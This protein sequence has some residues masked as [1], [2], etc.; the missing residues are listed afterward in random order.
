MT[1]P[2]DDGRRP[3][4]WLRAAAAVL[5]ASA[6]PSSAS[7]QL[8]T[9]IDLDNDSFNFWQA[10]ARR[11]DREYSQG[12]RVNLL[13]PT[14][15]RIARRLL[16]GPHRCTADAVTRDCRMTSIAAMQRIYTP[17]LVVR[18]RQPSE[19]PF[20]G[21]LGAEVGVQR[22]RTSGLTAWSVT[23]GVTGAPSFGEAAQ[24]GVH[25]LLGFAE[26]DGWDAQL[27]T[28]VAF[29][30]RF[31]GARQLLRVEQPSTGL[32][33]IVAPTW[34]ARVGT[35]ATDATAGISLTTGL[36]PPVPWVTGARSSGDRWGIFVRAGATQSVVARN[37]FLDGTAFTRSAGVTRN[38]LVG[39][40]ELGVGVRA[41]VGMLEWRMHRQS[42]EYRLQPRPHAYS[43]F[44]FSLR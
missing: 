36:R 21:W 39:D 30:L 28:E 9:R 31:D 3:A 19:R 1:Q 44:A 16:G 12:A 11:A 33:L 29:A 27:P 22:D 42:R 25:R 15:G 24:K 14:H 38:L 6:L 41:P 4:G 26:P 35:L 13:W 5:L 37:L 20:A 23:V 40:V 17:D 7:A 32:R 18:R 34:S 10:P 43:T 8:L 2:R